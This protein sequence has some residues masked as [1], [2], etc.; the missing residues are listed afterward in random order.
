MQLRPLPKRHAGDQLFV[1][2]VQ[3]RNVSRRRR[4]VLAENFL[5]DP[6]AALHGTGALGNELEARMPGIVIIPPRFAS[7][8]VTL[9][10]PARRS[11]RPV[12]RSRPASQQ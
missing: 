8:I 5:Q 1:L 12:R 7:L 11:C 3:R 2:L 9:R 10:S 6:H 4:N